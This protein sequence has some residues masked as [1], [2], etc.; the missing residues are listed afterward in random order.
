MNHVAAAEQV[1]GNVNHTASTSGG[2]GPGEILRGRSVVGRR[3]AGVADA[4]PH[5][6]RDR[7]GASVGRQVP[8]AHRAAGVLCDMNAS[9]QRCDGRVSRQRVIAR[10]VIVARDISTPPLSTPSLLP[11]LATLIALLW[12]CLIQQCITLLRRGNLV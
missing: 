2:A 11:L 7:Q 3:S 1:T 5:P 8:R 4:Q 6:K 10:N 9:A 12:L